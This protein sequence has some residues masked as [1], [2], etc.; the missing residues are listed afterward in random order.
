[1]CEFNT[2]MEPIVV[3]S[4]DKGSN[5]GISLYFGLNELN[6]LEN[7]GIDLKKNRRFLVRTTVDNKLILVPFSQL[8]FTMNM[9]NQLDS[10][11]D[12]G[13]DEHE[14]IVEDLLEIITEK[15]LELSATERAAILQTTKEHYTRHNL[16]NLVQVGLRANKAATQALIKKYL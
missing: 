3:T 14:A 8:D 5:R 6:Q 11:M 1:M 9:D 12:L 13:K 10:I 7:Q 16:R 4:H 15:K 2:E